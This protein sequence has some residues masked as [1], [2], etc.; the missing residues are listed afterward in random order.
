MFKKILLKLTLN[1][2]LIFEV[3]FKLKQTLNLILNLKSLNLLYLTFFSKKLRF[4]M[5]LKEKSTK[6]EL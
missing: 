6:N 4:T 3:K 2:S 1:L 5:L